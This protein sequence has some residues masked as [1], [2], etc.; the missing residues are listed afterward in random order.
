MNYGARRTDRTQAPIVD[1]YRATGLLSVAVTSAVGN[2]FPDIV[3][4][5]KKHCPHC[6]HPLPYNW[7]FEIKDGDKKPSARKL[8]PP[9]VA[10]H[11]S[12]KGHIQVVETVAE[13]LAAVGLRP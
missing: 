11:A 1:A 7:M 10:F 8:T 4:G 6:T 5:G 13:A 9:Q 2:G 3:V 12:W